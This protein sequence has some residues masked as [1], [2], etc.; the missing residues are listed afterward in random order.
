MDPQW[1]GEASNLPPD[2]VYQQYP[3]HTPN[4]VAQDIL[5]R[6]IRKLEKKLDNLVHLMEENNRLL[7][8]MTSAPQNTVVPGSGGNTVVVRM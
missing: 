2:T 1:L 4:I 6:R 7:E 5:S 8:A 3:G